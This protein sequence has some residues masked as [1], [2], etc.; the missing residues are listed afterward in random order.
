MARATVKFQ[1][2]DSVKC[3][4]NSYSE[5]GMA[6]LICGNLNSDSNVYMLLFSTQ[7]VIYICTCYGGVYKR[8][9]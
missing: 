6:T 7:Y 9:I 1:E 5:L 3:S 4:G 8:F 2:L